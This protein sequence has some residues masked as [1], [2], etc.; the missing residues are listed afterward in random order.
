MRK[1]IT[2]L[3]SRGVLLAAITASLYLAL[4][5]LVYTSQGFADLRPCVVVCCAP[6]M[7]PHPQPAT[8]L[9]VSLLD[10]PRQKS[11]DRHKV[12]GLGLSECLMAFFDDDGNPYLGAKFPAFR[13]ACTPGKQT[14]TACYP[15]LVLPCSLGIQKSARRTSIIS[16]QSLQPGRHLEPIQ[17]LWGLVH[18]QPRQEEPLQKRCCGGST[19]VQATT[20]T[21]ITHAISFTLWYAS[22]LLR[23]S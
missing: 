22:A 15:W 17:L 21:V 11:H 14:L 18:C 23:P 12:H 19:M 4:G 1:K 3:P 7:N 10:T 9:L 20:V 6:R 16:D 13:F 5:A 2:R 8:R